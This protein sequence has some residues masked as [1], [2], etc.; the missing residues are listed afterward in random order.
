[1]NIQ[2][3]NTSKKYRTIHSIND[4]DV[5]LIDNYIKAE[6]VKTF[7]DYGCHFGHLSIYLAK[8][9]DI[10]IYAVDNFTGTTDDVLMQK[11]IN[12]LTN[13]YNFYNKVTS[14]IAENEPYIGKIIL[15]YSENYLE[16]NNTEIDFAFIDS[17]HRVEEAN[18]FPLILN[19]VK[20]GGII[21]GHDYTKNPECAQGVTLG[22]ELIESQC[23]WLRNAYTWFMRKNNEG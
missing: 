22:I 12:S 3:L 19:K 23:T 13:S 10:T 1:M 5:R 21:G 15:Q 9:Y 8:T 14:N 20:P 18:E 2:N 11:T 6:N 4:N 17:S 16:N 7:L